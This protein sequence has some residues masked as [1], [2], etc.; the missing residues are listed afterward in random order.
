[1]KA[2]TVLLL[3]AAVGFFVL[4]S[5]WTKEIIP[6]W[7]LMPVMVGSL[8]TVSLYLERGRLGEVY[9]FKPWHV[10]AGAASAIFL[11]G[12]FWVGHLISTRLLPFASE[13]VESIYTIRSGQNPWVIAAL[14]LFI[15]GPAEEIFWR[16]F[17]Q[18][19]LSSRYGIVIGFVAATAVYALVHVWSF[20]FMLITAA[21][22]CGC[23]WGLLFIIT[24][25]LWPCIISHTVWDVFIFI[26]LPIA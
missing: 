10:A 19:R 7:V 26:L 20:N 15:I 23:F 2:F 11:Y 21:A 14:L 4:F 12:V 3:F 13:Q 16:S 1:M 8:A 9:A 22:I 5:P 18:R 25:S 6:F 17:V 24:R